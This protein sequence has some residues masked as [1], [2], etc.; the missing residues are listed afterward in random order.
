M[1]SPKTLV[2]IIQT[3][4]MT[5][6]KIKNINDFQTF[7]FEQRDDNFVQQDNPSFYKTICG[8]KFSSEV[9]YILPATKQLENIQFYD[10]LKFITINNYKIGDKQLEILKKH[11]D[12]LLNVTHLHIWNIKQNDLK[13][14]SIFPNLTHLLVSHIR[15]IDFSFSGIDYLKNLNTLCLLSTPKIVNFNFIL[16]TQK[17]T[18]KNLSLQLTSNLTSIKGID[19][20][21]NLENLSLL[22]ST[23]ESNKKVDLENLVGIE[24]LTQLKSFEISYFRFDIKELKDKLSSLPELKEFTIDNIKYENQ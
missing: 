15:K 24:K 14:L 7:L 13:L 10:N 9:L 6:E 5:L 8:T 12:K 11:K 23:P 18:V 16:D 20:Y 22:A 3:I 4:P 17:L 19:K 2:A 1:A 21:K